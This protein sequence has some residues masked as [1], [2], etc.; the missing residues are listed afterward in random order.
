[1]TS[2]DGSSSERS[3]HLVLVGLTG[4]GKSTVGRACAQRLE[5]DYVDTDREVEK[6]AGRS[7]RKIFGD[8]GESTFRRLE[9]EALDAILRR[10]APVVVATGGGIVES[11]ENRRLLRSPGARVVWLLAG[12]STVIGRLRPGGHRPLLDADPQGTLHEMWRVR[13]PLYREVADVIV[14]VE[15]RSLSEVVEAV[16]R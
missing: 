4:S 10:P 9:T 13:E 12:P 7:I 14:S 11:E 16:L 1:M 15:H 3:P 5:R 6:A 8:S 2:A